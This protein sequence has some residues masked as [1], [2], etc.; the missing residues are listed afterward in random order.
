MWHGEEVTYSG[1]VIS[2]VGARLQFRPAAP[3]RIL[4]A[5]RGRRMLALAGEIADIAHLASLFVNAEHQQENVAIVLEGASRAGRAPGSFEIDV[6]VPIS[7][8]RDRATAR[9][10]ALRVAAQGLLWI[11]GAEK[12]SRGRS[13]WVPP[14]QLDAPAGLVDALSSWP[15]WEKAELP[16]ELGRMI[17][18]HVLDQF[19]IAG[20]PDECAA[21]LRAHL[22]A[23]P[24]ATGVRLKL[25]PPVGPNAVDDYRRLIRAIGDVIQVVRA[26]S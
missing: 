11:A 7:V 20:D 5:A 8:S 14:P 19:S 26:N 22:A 18:D 12:Y 4:V 23:L 21:R 2:V 25:P 16:D 10:Q 15:M 24:E 1:R 6:S 3:G 17:P 9:R 13:D